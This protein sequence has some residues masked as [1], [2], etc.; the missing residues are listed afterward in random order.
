MG[1]NFTKTVK[2][3]D[4]NSEKL[5]LFLEGIHDS[6]REFVSIAFEKAD[7]N[8]LITNNEKFKFLQFFDPAAIFKA[9]KN[10]LKTTQVMSILTDIQSKMSSKPA[11]APIK[12]L[13]R[14]EKVNYSQLFQKTL[15]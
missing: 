11:Q 8:D 4:D 14:M 6:I 12:M 15:H 13:E 5:E 1:N 10:S 2:E 9:D 3:T 7:I